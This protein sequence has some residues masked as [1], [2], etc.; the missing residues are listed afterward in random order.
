[1]NNGITQAIVELRQAE[2]NFEYA[3][4]EFV[5]I[6]IIQLLAAKMKVDMLYRLR[7][8]NNSNPINPVNLT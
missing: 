4:K 2:Q 1:M 5:D 7:K 3:N 6:A 8:Q